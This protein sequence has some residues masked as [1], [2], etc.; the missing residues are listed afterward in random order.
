MVAGNSTQ[1]CFG[2]ENHM[3]TLKQGKNGTVKI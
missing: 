1:L 2:A 3:H